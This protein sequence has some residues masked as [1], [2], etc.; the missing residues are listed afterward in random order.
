MPE[1]LYLSDEAVSDLEEI[2][3]FIA[4]D[5]IR[6]ADGFIDQLYKKCLEISELKS[7]GRRRDELSQGLVSI[8]HKKYVIFF[9]HEN[10]RI[11]I[12]RI[13]RSSR[14]LPRYFEH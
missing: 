5:S 8:A 10:D 9:I 6:N 1:K 14:D 11:E 4:Q 13:L 3:T 12:V 2:W 7:I